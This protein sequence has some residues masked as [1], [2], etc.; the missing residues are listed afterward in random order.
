MI[1]KS[2]ST[3][4]PNLLKLIEELFTPFE[5]SN[6]FHPSSNVKVVKSGKKKII[7]KSSKIKNI[8]A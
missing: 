3:I 5:S 2:K 1:K 4:S 8:R 7:K 6:K